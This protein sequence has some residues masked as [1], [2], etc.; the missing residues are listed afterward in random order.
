MDKITSSGVNE[1]EQAKSDPSSKIH[2]DPIPGPF[3]IL[4]AGKS[5]MTIV[6]TSANLPNAANDRDASDSYAKLG[7]ELAHK[8]LPI[9][10]NLD[11]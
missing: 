8:N 7:Q 11:M 6:K 4:P 9:F 10:H 5:Y 1:C 2:H 3:I